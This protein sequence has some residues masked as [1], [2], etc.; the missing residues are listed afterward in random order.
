MLVVYPLSGFSADARWTQVDNEVRQEID[1]DEFLRIVE[2]QKQ[3]G[4]ADTDDTDTVE[5]FVA[6]GG[7]V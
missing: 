5:A 2:S 3:V 7:K 1:L 4:G 6:L